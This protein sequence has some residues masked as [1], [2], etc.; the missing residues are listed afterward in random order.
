MMTRMTGEPKAV[1]DEALYAATV[2]K[3]S[4]IVKD[5][6]WTKEEHSPYS[7]TGD[8]TI[9]ESGRSLTIKEVKVIWRTATA[10]REI[11]SMIQ[12]CWWKEVSACWERRQSL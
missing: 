12:S 1:R 5:V 7:I 4:T 9:L 8:V 11:R 10:R 2:I 6:V 3:G